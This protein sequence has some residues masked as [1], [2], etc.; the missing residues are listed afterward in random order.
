[1]ATIRG[2]SHFSGNYYRC[3]LFISS[4]V[5]SLLLISCNSTNSGNYIVGDIRS[6]MSNQTVLQLADEI[7][8]VTYIPLKISA[9]D[10]SIIGGITGYAITKKYVYVHPIEESGIVLFDKQGNFIKTIVRYGQGPGEINGTLMRMQTDE[11]D[12]RLYIYTSERIFI[13]DLEGSFIE[14]LSPLRSSIFTSS[15]GSNRFAA[16]AFPYTTFRDGSFG[17]G[18]FTSKGDT[19]VIKNDFYSSLVAPEK[20]GF[21]LGMTPP[22]YSEQTKSVL[23]KTGSNDTLFRMT[24]NHIL[25]ACILNLRNSNEEI[26]RSLDAAD[27][28]SL[29]NGRFEGTGDIYISDL[30]ETTNQFYFRFRYNMDYYVASVSKQTGKTLVEKCQLPAS[31]NELGGANPILGMVGTISYNR[32]PIWGSIENNYLVQIVTPSELDLY[33]NSDSI[34][35][36]ESLRTVEEEDNPIFILYKIKE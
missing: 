23:F 16:V 27:F 7:E 10:E 32:F 6:A 20:S 17:V 1:M 22:A 9:N 13:Y 26:V 14:T 24:D 25:P 30:F 28:M 12:N 31:L 5:I 34:S 3:N 15:I 35:I 29:R 36:P 8:N 4:L 2:L 19:V 11:K 18:I 33:K 21:T